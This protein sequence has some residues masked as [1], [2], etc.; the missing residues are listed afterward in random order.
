M[1]GIFRK[2]DYRVT[3]DYWLKKNIDLS[4]KSNR[5]DRFFENTGKSTGN[6]DLILIGWSEFFLTFIALIVRIP[7]FVSRGMVVIV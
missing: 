5:G 2:I 7:L 1:A 3:N 6:D 4:I